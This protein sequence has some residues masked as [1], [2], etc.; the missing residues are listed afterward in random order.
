MRYI[1]IDLE[2]TC[3]K[4]GTR[5]SRMEIIEVG[6]VCLQDG[7]IIDEFARFVKPI[8]QPKLSDFC[9]ELT[10]IQQKD[11]DDAEH[12]YS[13]FNE[14]LDWIGSEPFTWCSWGAYDY[15][16][17]KIDCHRHGI[18]FPTSFEQHINIKQQFS[19]VKGV[20]K[21]GM[22]RALQILEIPLEGQHHRGIDDARNIAKIA[23][24][25]LPLVET[26]E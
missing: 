3:W 2:A 24:T 4:H 15:S 17:F 7:V 26:Q 10:T 8:E 11:V 25:I 13:V 21:C 22:K 5:P 12:F 6:A 14:L 18:E 20:K 23:M 9:V 19:A 1:I 16:Q